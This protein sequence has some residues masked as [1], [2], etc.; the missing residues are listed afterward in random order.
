M[1][2]N[3][4]QCFLCHDTPDVLYKLCECLESNVCVECYNN[5]NTQQMNRCA[6]CRRNFT[7][8]NTRDYKEFINIIIYVFLLFVVS[9]S[10]ELFP[11]LYIYYYDNNESQIINNIFLGTCI[12]FIT[13]GNVILFDLIQNIIYENT[14]KV[15]LSLYLF[16]S[17]YILI[18][19]FIV[20]YISIINTMI[21]YSVFVIGVVYGAPFLFFSMI[22]VCDKYDNLKKYVNKKSLI[23]KIKIKSF[24]FQ[25]NQ[26]PIQP[27]QEKIE[28]DIILPLQYLAH[29]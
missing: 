11:P 26:Q 21:Y 9:L 15:L 23:S 24:I 22:K 6:I 5:D 13:I 27:E 18:M 12:F 25:N 28:Q 19:F 8:N 29:L 16:K 2:N 20:N 3:N 10:I 4:V 7:Y 14:T 17:F 1:E